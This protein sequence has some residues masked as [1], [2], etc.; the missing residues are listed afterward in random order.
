MAISAVMTANLFNGLNTTAWTG[1]V[2]IKGVSGG[3]AKGVGGA[4]TEG[5]SS[6][7]ETCAEDT[8]GNVNETCVVDVDGMCTEGISSPD[9][10]CAEDVGNANKTC[11]ED[12]EGV[13]AEGIS[14]SVKTCAEYIRGAIGDISSKKG[15][16]EEA[17]MSGEGRAGMLLLSWLEYLHEL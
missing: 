4:C 14:G 2:D 9:E 3:C 13:C 12:I 17:C 10:T 15:E 1:W 16:E 7:D 8:A 6:P 11:A 5:I